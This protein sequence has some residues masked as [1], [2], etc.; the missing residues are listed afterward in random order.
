MPTLIYPSVQ[1]PVLLGAEQV[2]YSRFGF[3][4]SEPVR[5]KIKPALAVALAASSGVIWDVL[6]PAP[7][8]DQ[9]PARNLLPYSE[10]VRVK[11]RLITGAQQFLAF[12]PA[13]PFPETPLYSKFGY[14]WSEPVRVKRRLGAGLQPAMI[15][16]PAA[17]FPEDPNYAKFN[18]PWS[19]PVVKAKWQVKTKLH[20]AYNP[21]AFLVQAA[22]FPE[23]PLYDK[24]GF[25]WSEPI[26]KS[27]PL[28]RTGLQAAAF[29]VQAAPF[30][31]TVLYDKYAFPWSEP[32]VKTKA[33]LRTAANPAAF[34]T[35]A[36]PFEEFVSPA[37]WYLNLAEPK[38]FKPAML[39]AIQSNLTF[40]PVQPLIASS[41][42]T[43]ANTKVRVRFV[44]FQ[45]TKLTRV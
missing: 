25:P 33:R 22:P 18:F 26:V 16:A 1:Q 40:F 35:Q 30:G 38:R 31:E 32:I 2:T 6:T 29:I 10:P 13:A 19:E 36:A 27:K 15:F 5:Q 37:S 8:P 43:I 34:L 17:P 23:P 28:L 11:P 7:P 24:F 4:W 20:A 21:A 14:P 39:T 45:T 9:D 41:R 3:A 12:A 44:G 42:M